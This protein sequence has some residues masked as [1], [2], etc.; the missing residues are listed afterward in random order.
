MA[1]KQAD[2]KK[3][4][5]MQGNKST[6]QKSMNQPNTQTQKRYQDSKKNTKES[7]IK[8]MNGKHKQDMN[9]TQSDP[10]AKR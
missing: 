5:K 4:H 1:R 10:K 7:N 3:L 9:Y 8:S 2:Q 6:L